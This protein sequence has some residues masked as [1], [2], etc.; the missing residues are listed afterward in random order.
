M[1]QQTRLFSEAGHVIAGHGA[2]LT[3]LMY[4]RPG[5]RVLEM[6]HEKW[7]HSMYWLTA[8]KCGLDYTL[9][10]AEPA[11]KRKAEIDD[12]LVDPEPLRAY[13]EQTCGPRL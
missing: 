13:L 5:T 12:M 9:M 2:G 3:N 4:C 1:D 6:L 11:G 8:A 7:G 10:K